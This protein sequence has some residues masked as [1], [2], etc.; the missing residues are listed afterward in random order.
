MLRDANTQQ[1]ISCRSLVS[2]GILLSVTRCHTQARKVPASR[3]C[4][5][6]K[7]MFNDFNIFSNVPV[8]PYGTPR[9]LQPPHK[10]KDALFLA[11]LLSVE[12]GEFLV[13][14]E[15]GYLA[16][17]DHPFELKTKRK[18]KRAT[19]RQW[20]VNSFYYN[21]KYLFMA[22]NAHH[23]TID[24]TKMT[25][26]RLSAFT[27]SLE[28]PFSQKHDPLLANLY[29]TPLLAWDDDQVIPWDQLCCPLDG[30]VTPLSA[31]VCRKTVFWKRLMGR[32]WH[33]ELCPKCLGTFKHELGMMN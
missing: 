2:G 28:W 12:N 26:R 22:L 29:R 19:V 20:F 30:P 33:L 15:N 14:L 1:L 7:T 11:K 8:E 3:W 16:P 31:I 13:E 27:E 18:I 25:S 6:L 4:E 23:V 17:E 21:R 24:G 32:E 10:T 5:S 9:D